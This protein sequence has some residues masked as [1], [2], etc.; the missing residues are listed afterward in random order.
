MIKRCFKCKKI[1]TVFSKS[2][3]IENHT[4]CKACALEMAKAKASKKTYGRYSRNDEYYSGLIVENGIKTYLA[5]KPILTCEE[6]EINREK[7]NNLPIDIRNKILEIPQYKIFFK[8]SADQNK[9]EQSMFSSNSVPYYVTQNDQIPK[10][11]PQNNGLYYDP[12]K[13]SEAYKMVI[14]EVSQIANQRYREYLLKA[15]GGKNVIGGAHIYYAIEADTLYEKYGIYCINNPMSL[16][17]GLR[18]D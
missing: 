5:S 3:I 8:T 6:I 15:F 7:I 10:V 12:V 18:I 14:K 9:T 17:K 4:F 2:S 11:L 1:L 13:D 16:N